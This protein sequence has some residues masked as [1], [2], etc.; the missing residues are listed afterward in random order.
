MSLRK[1]LINSLNNAKVDLNFTQ[2]QNKCERFYTL[3]G[4]QDDTDWNTFSCSN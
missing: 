1:P 2:K 3:L 4:C